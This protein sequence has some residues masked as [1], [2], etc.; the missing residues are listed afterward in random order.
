MYGISKKKDRMYDVE[1]DTRSDLKFN[2]KDDIYI[3]ECTQ[4][5]FSDNV[6]RLMHRDKWPL[7]QCLAISFSQCGRGTAHKEGEEKEKE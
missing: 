2:G 1:F 5:D 4:Q 7:K 6:R 3:G